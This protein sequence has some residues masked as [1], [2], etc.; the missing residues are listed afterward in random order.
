MN[1]NHKWQ[2]FF[3][4]AKIADPQKQL[5][6]FVDELDVKR[7]RVLELGCWDGR[8]TFFLA[9][10]G[11]I[12]DSLDNSQ[13]ILHQLKANAI[14]LEHDKKIDYIKSNLSNISNL[15][16]KYD[17]IISAV[18]IFHEIGRCAVEDMIK[19]IKELLLKDGFVY[20]SYFSPKEGTRMEKNKYYP[21]KE[22]LLELFGDKWKI[23]KYDNEILKHKHSI[24]EDGHE[25]MHKHNICHL[26]ITKK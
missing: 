6:S 16:N 7:R 11:F 15:K 17:L 14:K 4:D 8:N 23:W 10:K 1:N 9:S 5:V 13:S 26:F 22:E 19:K 21:E 2:K 20:F 24:N 12:V 25:I 18:Y 3:N